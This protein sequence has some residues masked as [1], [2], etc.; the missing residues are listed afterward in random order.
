MANL[1]PKIPLSKRTEKTDVATL[2]EQ[3]REEQPHE[4][5]KQT[6]E[7]QPHEDQEQN[8]LEVMHKSFVPAALQMAKASTERIMT[9]FGQEVKT[10]RQEARTQAELAQQARQETEE[11]REYAQQARQELTRLLAD[12]QQENDILTSE[13]VALK[14]LVR[15]HAERS[16][17]YKKSAE[18]EKK[19]ASEASR[20]SSS[21][22]RALQV[23]QEKHERTRKELEQ[24]REE[25]SEKLDAAKHEID[26]AKLDEKAANQRADHLAMLAFAG[27]VMGLLA[28]F[29]PLGALW[30]CVGAAIAAYVIYNNAVR[31]KKTEAKLENL[32]NK[33]SI[34]HG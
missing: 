13:N 26:A 11:L 14:A 17:S 20:K 12:E 30:A 33:E 29:G 31:G 16:D 18:E 28:A 32:E 1:P 24:L 8:L 3:A 7:A 23:E 21:S 6:Q 25:S 27:G 34:S 10:A 19:R 4:E 2:M 22:R 5:E 15:E 9:A